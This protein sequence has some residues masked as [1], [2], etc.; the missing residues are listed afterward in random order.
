MDIAQILQ[1]SGALNA[2]SHE[3]G[4]DQQ[5]AAQ[6]AAA[7]LPAILAGFQRQGGDQAGAG[8][9]LGGLLGS[10]GGGALIDAVTRDAPTPVEQGNSILGEIFGTREVSRDVAGQ[11]AQ[12][13]GLDPA[14]LRRMLPI[15]AML[16]GGYLATRGGGQGAA[17][18][19]PAPAAPATG[20][21]G[22]LLGSVIGSVLGGGG[23]QGGAA[24]GLGSMLDANGNGNPLDDILGRLGGLRR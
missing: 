15:V 10:L 7:L 2:V 24:G 13:T 1:Q 21:L 23:Q 20:G 6:G 3:L 19:A 14:L 4:V 22:D 11:A 12:T 16:V 8:A 9:G 17:P 18:A 5:T